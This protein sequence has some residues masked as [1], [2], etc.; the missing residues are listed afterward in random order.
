MALTK[1]QA[2]MVE[3]TGTPS[4]STFLRGDGA[5]ATSITSGTAVTASGTS[6]DF[7]APFTGVKRITVMFQG[8][9]TNGTSH[10]RVRIGSGSLQ[11]TGYTSLSVVTN[12]SN[13]TGGITDTT[14]FVVFSN[15]ATNTLMGQMILTLVSG[16]IWVASHQIRNSATQISGGGGD[17]TLSGVLDRLSLVSTDTFD[18]GLIN[19]LW[20]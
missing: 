14:G 15:V 20:E 9:S 10:M 8:I 2:G 12:T 1:V 11:I 18:A 16:N 19:I 7:T 6:V 3:A 5:W 13:T 4:S 17:V